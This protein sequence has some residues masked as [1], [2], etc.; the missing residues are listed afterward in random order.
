MD[1]FN[2]SRTILNPINTSLRKNW[3]NSNQA[4]AFEKQFL[5]RGAYLG[6]AP[7]SFVTHVID[8]V[9][10]I[11]SGAGAIVT[12]GTQE[13]VNVF[14]SNHLCASKSLLAIPYI[15]LLKAINVTADVNPTGD[16][17]VADFVIDSL[18]DIAND[19]L[20]S[21]NIFTRHVTSRL[22]YAVLAISAL[23]ARTVDGVIGVI[24]ALF[25]FFTVGR[26]E[27]FN[28]LAMNG[29][30]ATGIINDLFCCTIR[31][32][33]PGERDMRFGRP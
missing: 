4:N 33:N 9:I 26:Y 28:S 6:L 25:S 17:I 18:K 10:G 21:D 7:L 19:C 20:R 29:L 30:G 13:A 5:A 12:G 2:V 32:I 3:V 8:T 15:Y 23:V 16:G 11:G 1:Y 27:F 22:S 31:F 14:A 24:A